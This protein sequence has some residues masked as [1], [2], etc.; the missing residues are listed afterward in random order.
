MTGGDARRDPGGG[1]TVATGPLLEARAIS[2]SFPGAAP[3]FEDVT[4]EIARGSHVGI[5]G[6][7]GAG[8]ST[9]LRLFAG[10]LLPGAG[11]IRFD[12]VPMRAW[13]RLALARRMAYVPQSAPA[14]L[15]FT[16]MEVALAGRF[17]HVGYFGVESAA[18][19][20]KALDALTRLDAAGLAG[21]PYAELSGGEQARVQVAR[22]LAQEPDLLLL[23]EP[24]AFLD[25][26]ARLDLYD[27]L[28]EENRR[29]GLTVVVVT[30]DLNLA[31]EYCDRLVLLAKGGVVAS[32]A[33]DGVLDE[34]RIGALYGCRVAVDVNPATGRRRVTPL[35][36]HARDRLA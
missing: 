33:P 5:V 29:R 16:A 26:G 28:R 13:R 19:R 32:G 8:K 23:D 12:G 11:E 4:L 34:A 30:H 6:P 7:N 24:T 14:D 2:F 10:G 22:A 9:L 21:R 20:A 36:R 31:A 3:L 18:D 15:P 17:A 35:P 1:G 27:R 25:L